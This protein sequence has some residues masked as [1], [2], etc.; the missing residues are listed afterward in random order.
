MTTNGLLV[1]LITGLGALGI[2]VCALLYFRHVRLPRP[3]IGVFDQNDLLTICLVIIVLPLLYL[4][5]PVPLLTSIFALLFLNV[6]YQGLH[7][8]FPRLVALPLALFLIG[9]DILT[10]LV[11]PAHWQPGTFA[12]WIVND[13]VMVLV[14]VV[15]ANLYAQL[16][17]RMRHIALLAL[18]LAC[19]DGIFAW[20]I[21]LTPLLVTHFA[22]TVFDPV[23]GFAIGNV[24]SFF[25]IGD[26]F[27]FALV[28]S[29]AY[30]GFG[31]W[32]VLAS[33]IVIVC[34]GIL[35]PTIGLPLLVMLLGWRPIT[36]VPVQVFLGPAVWLLS[37]WLAKRSQERS[38]S[39]WLAAEERVAGPQQ[40]GQ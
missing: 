3:P 10:T 8:I 39:Q 14:V 25:G 27:V 12:H 29:V 30:K 32:G 36:L 26:L 21:P 2:P 40:I 16:G 13:L 1:L 28:V 17:M 19:Y 9:A 20:V 6:F 5:M 18:F 22:G 4:V 33:F 35:L 24:Q 23:F 37:A 31:L 11:V 34:F 7:A 38:M 15:A